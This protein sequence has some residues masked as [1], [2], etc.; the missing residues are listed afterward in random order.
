MN[1]WTL[2]GLNTTTD[3]R[4]VEKLAHKKAFCI[5]SEFNGSQVSMTLPPFKKLTEN[6]LN[7]HF[8]PDSF[9]H[10]HVVDVFS[11]SFTWL[12]MMSMKSS[13]PSVPP[14]TAEL[15]NIIL[16]LIALAFNNHI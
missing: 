12:A 7:M 8:N 10:K 2:L 11:R 5:I 15:V 4:P 14:I 16:L 1:F 6:M 9:F 13:S 3:E